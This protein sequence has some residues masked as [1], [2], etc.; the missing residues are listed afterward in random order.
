MAGNAFEW[1]ADWYQVDYYKISPAQNPKGPE[2]EGFKIMRGGGW[3]E[4]SDE[5]RSA[6]RFGG[7]LDGT[8]SRTGFRIAKDTDNQ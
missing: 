6:F 3:P 4:F 8:D 7:F 2:T 1:V 5:V